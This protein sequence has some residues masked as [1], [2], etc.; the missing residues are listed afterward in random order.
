LNFFVYSALSPPTAKSSSNSTPSLP[1]ELWIKVLQNL[2]DLSSLWSYR[3]ISRAFMS[4][5]EAVLL[6]HIIPHKTVLR[7]NCRNRKS[8]EIGMCTQSKFL[9]YSPEKRLAHY[10]VTGPTDSSSLEEY[11]RIQYVASHDK[12]GLL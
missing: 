6:T 7:Y 11:V 5:V 1:P 4:H 2:D 12:P 8:G 3:P 9:H 10:D